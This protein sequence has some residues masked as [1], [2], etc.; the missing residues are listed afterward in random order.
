MAK[1]VVVR[2]LLPSGFIYIERALLVQGAV[3]DRCKLREQ[4]NLANGDGFGET[5][6]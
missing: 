1:H 6:Q 5:T 3:W 4:V 2:V